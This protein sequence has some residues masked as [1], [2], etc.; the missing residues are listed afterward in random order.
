VRGKA[1]TFRGSPSVTR[2]LVWAGFDLIGQG[3]N[4]ARDFGQLALRDTITNL[5][6]A[7]LA[8]AGAG[9]NRSSAF[10]PAII[11]RNG[12]RIAYLSYSQIGPADFVATNRSPGTAYSTSINGV[13]SQIAAAKRQADY[14]I[15]SFHWGTERSYRPTV[16]QVR[17]G[18][19]AIDAGA[20]A[21]LSHHPHVIQGVEYY[22]GGLIAY[23]L[24]NFVFSPGST[25]GHDT[26]ILSMKLSPSGVSDVTARAMF[27]DGSGRPTVARGGAARRINNVIVKTSRGRGTNSTVRG[28]VVELRR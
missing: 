14:V 10:R 17:F 4:H 8:H 27:I 11:E 18:R 9:V 15:V 12:A 23:S 20:D 28:G 21:V 22:R 24:G 3:N 19:A 1:F 26:M 13:K 5:N 6:R 16:R 2:G 7:G 25:A